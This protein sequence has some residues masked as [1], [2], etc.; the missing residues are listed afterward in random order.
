MTFSTSPNGEGAMT[1]IID[2]VRLLPVDNQ[3]VHSLT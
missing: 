2:F 1:L 3:G